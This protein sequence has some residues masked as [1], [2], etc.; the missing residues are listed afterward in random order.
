MI[1]FINQKTFNSTF[2]YIE[3]CIK[4]QHNRPVNMKDLF[5]ISVYIS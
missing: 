4:D 3:I 1:I 5:Q 2:N